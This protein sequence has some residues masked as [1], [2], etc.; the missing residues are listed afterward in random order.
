MPYTR[1]E[2]HT[3]KSLLEQYG[4]SKGH[5]V[6]NR[7]RAQG[8]LGQGSKDR[9]MRRAAEARKTGKTHE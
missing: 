4:S 5:D 6:F 1:R 7:T 2:E 3:L 8:D 9:M